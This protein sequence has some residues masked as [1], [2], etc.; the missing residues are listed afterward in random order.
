MSEV[1]Y[2]EELHVVINDQKIE[3]TLDDP[4]KITKEIQ[5]FLVNLQKNQK[6]AAFLIAKKNTFTISSKSK[7][8]R[9]QYL[10]K[11][12]VLLGYEIPGVS[13]YPLEKLQAMDYRITAQ[14]TQKEIES[15]EGFPYQEISSYT[16]SSSNPTINDFNKCE[17]VV[18]PCTAAFIL[19]YFSSEDNVDKMNKGFGEEK[20]EPFLVQ[21]DMPIAFPVL[22]QANSEN[23][24]YTFKFADIDSTKAEVFQKIFMHTVNNLTKLYCIK[25]TLTDADETDPIESKDIADKHNIYVACYQ[26]IETADDELVTSNIYLLSKKGKEE[27]AVLEQAMNEIYKHNSVCKCKKCGMVYAPAKETDCTMFYHEGMQIPF[28]DGEM[29][30]YDD[31][32]EDEEGKPLKLH[33]YTCCGPIPINEQGCKQKENGEHEKDET[34]GEISRMSITKDVKYEISF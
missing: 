24:T 22:F 14:F 33:N 3:F 21:L 8:S 13:L 4:S 20:Q 5:Q 30:A 10:N 7:N 9:I 16:P 31:E 26:D 17:V 34:A 28:S 29:S 32:E 12:L 19:A 1:H 27:E 6:N 25:G 15:L 11:L 23:N 18:G 2:P